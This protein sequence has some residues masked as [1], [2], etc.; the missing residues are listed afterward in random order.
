MDKPT[1]AVAGEGMMEGN[2]A[3]STPYKCE[4]ILR[5]MLDIVNEGH[6]I[7]LEQDWGGNTLTIYVDE[8]HS[9]V[10]FP[11]DAVTFGDMIRDLHELLCNGAGLSLEPAPAGE[12]E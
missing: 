10:G 8:T 3:T 6:D 2:Q 5:K 12:G 7:V 4:A 9:H 1:P 11:D